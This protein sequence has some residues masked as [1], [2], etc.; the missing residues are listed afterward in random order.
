M[1]NSTNYF[2]EIDEMKISWRKLTPTKVN[3]P[4]QGIL[5]S[6]GSWVISYQS[7]AC[8]LNTWLKRIYDLLFDGVVIERQWFFIQ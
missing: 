5:M 6:F 1:L 2:Y 8:T 4:G 7:S 3:Y